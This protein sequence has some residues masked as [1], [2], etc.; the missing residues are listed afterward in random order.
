MTEIRY[1]DIDPDSGD[2]TCDA[3]V[4]Q[5]PTEMIANCVC[6]A[7]VRDMSLDDTY[8]YPNRE[9]YIKEL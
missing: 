5:C 3:L 1:K 6:S 4:C 8:D 7:L 2:I 9:F